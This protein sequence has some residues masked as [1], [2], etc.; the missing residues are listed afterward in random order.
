MISSKG[1]SLTMSLKQRSS[2]TAE[3]QR[4]SYT[5]LSRLAHHW[6]CT[7]LNTASVTDYRVDQI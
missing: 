7:S 3:R 4:V 5:H 2:A 6:S 1:L